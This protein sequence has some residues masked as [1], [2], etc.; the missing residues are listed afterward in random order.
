LLPSELVD[1]WV[2]F[3]ISPIAARLGQQVQAH[4]IQML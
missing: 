1:L 2:E 3:L 4:L